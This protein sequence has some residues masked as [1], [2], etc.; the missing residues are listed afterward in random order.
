M[1]RSNTFDDLFRGFN[2]QALHW[3]SQ[4]QEA[5][6]P[7]KDLITDDLK[8][9]VEKAYSL[10]MPKETE[11]PIVGTCEQCAKKLRRYVVGAGL[12][13]CN[14]ACLADWQKKNSEPELIS[15][16]IKIWRNGKKEKIQ[17]FKMPDGT[18]EA[19]TKNIL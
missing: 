4:H 18:F 17:Q 15:E 9:L 19:K 8:K 6:K 2:L 14:D 12:L 13:F 3:L 5:D 11:L 10:D 1:S 16:R 7:Y